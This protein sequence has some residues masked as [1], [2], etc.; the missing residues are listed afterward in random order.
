MNLLRI[1]NQKEPMRPWMERN[2]PDAVLTEEDIKPLQEQMI[3]AG[4]DWRNTLQAL[5]NLL[6]FKFDL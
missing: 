1:A 4:G 2:F 6:H 3:N 5:I